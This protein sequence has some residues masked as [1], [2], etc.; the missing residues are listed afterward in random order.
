MTGEEL[1]NEIASYVRSQGQ[2]FCSWSDITAHISDIRYTLPNDMTQCINLMRR[3]H[4]LSVLEDDGELQQIGV[5][6]AKA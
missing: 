2:P 4:G 1:A 3:D 6:N 5:R